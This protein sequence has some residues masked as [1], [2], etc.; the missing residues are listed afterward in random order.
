MEHLVH[1]VLI[2]FSTKTNCKPTIIKRCI[3]I[4]FFN[5]G[6]SLHQTDLYGIARGS[7]QSLMLQLVEFRS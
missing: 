2:P 4:S 3:W 7:K 1:L 6:V 5:A